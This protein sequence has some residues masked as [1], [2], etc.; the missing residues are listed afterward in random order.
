MGV[1]CQS[2][3]AHATAVEYQLG[4]GAGCLKE[5]RLGT[6]GCAP[7]PRGAACPACGACVGRD[8]GA[9]DGARPQ[10]ILLGQK[11]G[12]ARNAVHHR[13]R[14]GCHR[15]SWTS[16][17]RRSAAAQRQPRRPPT[18]QPHLSRRRYWAI[19]SVQLPRTKHWHAACKR[20]FLVF[21][22]KN[23]IGS[24]TMMHHDRGKATDTN[25]S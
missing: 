22:K 12:S 13:L 6:L 2:G 20:C 17:R 15:C 23:R 19:P 24:M 11:N 5:C 16:A 9:G 4:A 21:K 1:E 18:P 10:T 3:A 7:S 14:R 25:F 8:G